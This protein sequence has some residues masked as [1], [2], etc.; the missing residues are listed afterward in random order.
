MAKA[1]EDRIAIGASVLG[2]LPKFDG[3]INIERFLKNLEKKRQYRQEF[4][5][6][7]SNGGYQN[8]H[9]SPPANF[10]LEQEDQ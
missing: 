10:R 7:E 6:N 3:R 4:N 9:S 1:N 2:K 5:R 8:Y